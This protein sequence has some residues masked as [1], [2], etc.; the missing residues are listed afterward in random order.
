MIPAK[1]MMMYTYSVIDDALQLGWGV[2]VSSVCRHADVAD[3]ECK[4]NCIGGVWNICAINQMNIS[5]IDWFL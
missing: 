3:G 5:M 1:H 2:A 4:V